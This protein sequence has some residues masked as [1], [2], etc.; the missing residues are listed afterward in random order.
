VLAD[1]AEAMTF[2]EAKSMESISKIYHGDIRAANVI[3][4]DSFVAKLD[5]SRSSWV[6]RAAGPV[7][8]MAPEIL[9]DPK[10][11]VCSPHVADVWSFGSLCCEVLSSP[12]AVPY[13]EYD[14]KDSILR[15]MQH[16]PPM[17]Q[18]ELQ[19]TECI[20]QLLGSIF[21]AASSRPRA[22]SILALIDGELQNIVAP[23]GSISTLA[24]NGDTAS[25]VDDIETELEATRSSCRWRRES[26]PP[27]PLSSPAV[28]SP[29]LRNPRQQR[30]PRSRLSGNRGSEAPLRIAGG[31]PK[32]SEFE[33]DDMTEDTCSQGCA[34]PV[35]VIA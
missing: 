8:W 30:N 19:G 14:E 3:L 26:F 21:Q 34:Q 15:L 10:Y 18:S 11:E 32:P 4:G 23:R 7:Q 12:S 25:D 28:I 2:L 31:W 33:N 1:I 35:C 9:N 5:L 27:P 20:H 6:T 13:G 17:S 24:T 29:R 16:V 22:E